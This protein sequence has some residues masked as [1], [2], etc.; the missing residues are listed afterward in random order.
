MKNVK[1]NK[2]RILGDEYEEGDEK[3]QADI[4]R[5]LGQL[6]FDFDESKYCFYC[7]ITKTRKSSNFMNYSGLT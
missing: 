6:E 2:K 7:V 1:E 3:S 5:E 4:D